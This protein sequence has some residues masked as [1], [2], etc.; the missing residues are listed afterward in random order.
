MF[1]D[2][3][4]GELLLTDNIDEED[5]KWGEENRQTIADKYFD[6]WTPLPSGWGANGRDAD[7]KVIFEAE[8][9]KLQN[10]IDEAKLKDPDLKVPEIRW[11]YAMRKG[12]FHLGPFEGLGANV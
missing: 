4:Y 1:P 2:R 12:M 3:N 5:N 10:Q 7:R 11:K 6:P 8:K 9:Q